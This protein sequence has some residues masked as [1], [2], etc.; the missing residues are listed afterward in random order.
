MFVKRHGNWKHGDYA[1][2]TKESRHHLRIAIAALNGRWLGPLPWSRK[3]APG[4]AAY[5]AVRQRVT[6]RI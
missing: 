2:S 4:W 5:R 3:P 1:Q 6:P